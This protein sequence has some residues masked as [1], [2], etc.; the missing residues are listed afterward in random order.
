MS[1]EQL[2]EQVQHDTSSESIAPFHQ[3]RFQFS[4]HVTRTGRTFSFQ[5]EDRYKQGHTLESALDG[6]EIHVHFP[7]ERNEEIREIS[8]GTTIDVTAVLHEW[9]KYQRQLVFLAV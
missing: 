7:E 5:L 2:I 3:Q 6:M 4:L 9:K 1:L 8:R